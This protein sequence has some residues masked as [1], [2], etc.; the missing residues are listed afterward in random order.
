[1]RSDAAA[2]RRDRFTSILPI[3]ETCGNV[4]WT[5]YIVSFVG[6]VARNM[7][8]MCREVR[9]QYYIVNALGEEC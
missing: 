9:R 8:D 4:H 6:S 5:M 3:H 2:D 1:M 7:C